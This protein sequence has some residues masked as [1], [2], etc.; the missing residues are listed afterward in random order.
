MSWIPPNLAELC[1]PYSQ[2]S[3]CQPPV[4]L[5]MNF[6]AT[7]FGY[8]LDS[9]ARGVRPESDFLSF[10]P[11]GPG[12]TTT[13]VALSNNL[14]RSYQS[15]DY[16][17]SGQYFEQSLRIKR[18]VVKPV[19]YYN[20][21]HH[22]YSSNFGKRLEPTYRQFSP[23]PT[24]VYGQPEAFP[25]AHY[26]HRATAFDPQPRSYFHDNW[27]NENEEYAPPAAR[28]VFPEPVDSHAEEY[29]FIVV[30]AGSAGCVI[31]N[32][33]SEI[34]HWKVLLL[35]AG[36]EEPLVAEVPAFAPALRGS[37]I[38]W[39]YR[40]TR[41][42]RACRSK[43]GGTCS[44]SRGKVMGG[45]SV[46]NY[47]MYIRANM[48]DYNAWARMGNEGW[49]YDEVL[50]Y[51]KKSEANLDPEVVHKN[52]KYHSQH[53]YQTVEWFKYMDPNVRVVINGFEEAGY[54]FV[55]PNAATQLGTVHYQ[56]TAFRGARMSTN[57]AF[58][59]TIR[60][61][62]PNLTI[63][64]QAQATRVLIDP[65]TKVTHGVEYYSTRSAT[66]KV[67]R[68][69]REVIVSA[70][71]IDSPK[72]LQLSGVGP[73]EWLHG[74]GIQLVQDLPV[75]RNLQ[76]HVTTDGLIVQLSNATATS[77]NPE[78]IKRDAYEWLHS[79]TGPLSAHGS[80]GAGAF[81]QTPF[82]TSPDQPD[83][84]YCFD[85]TSVGDYLA[86]PT[87]SVETAVMPLA[88]YDGL[89][90]RPVLL[91]PRSRG[92][93]RLN[94]TDPVFG[95]PIIDPN[96]YGAEPDLEAML[97]GIRIFE[98]LL[99]TR[100][101]RDNGLR[102]LDVPLPSCVTYRFDSDD[103]WRCVLTEYTTTLYHPSCTCKMGPRGDPTAVVDP[104][105]RV[106]GVK[107][108][109]VADASIMPFVVR[110]NTNAPTIMI[111]EKASDMIKEDW[112][113]EGQDPGV[114]FGRR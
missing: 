67:A 76:D 57:A 65:T 90:V 43:R 19:T 16:Y 17:G 109:R 79:Q 21:L 62:R 100:A 2:V 23:Q 72:L 34:G 113:R 97:A 107:G 74:H 114:L 93:V 42:K 26:H 84:Q 37:N 77:K 27:N 18:Q 99:G 24:S 40:T 11:F 88:Y 41:M 38:D 68:A 101:F 35:E 6:L 4:M 28:A 10:A 104:R 83:M 39:Q 55:D 51:F 70:G 80:L 60:D 30:G 78:A 87:E 91:A 29:D 111:G 85:G 105:L 45:S 92:T 1:P 9:P 48:E 102:L 61:K 96:Y 22:Y 73:A 49:S 12:R 33:L 44:W 36:I 108:L 52:R 81:V 110:G 3:T 56:S 58:I 15:H 5:F 82:E 112:L 7:L 25:I 13:P 32:R 14:D 66:T 8:S 31:A 50:P 94:R 89:N 86:D 47:M 46:L 71:A 103:Y 53:G 63:Q 64:T 75:G 106:H 20:S 59:R 54:R 95:A 69:R 98:E